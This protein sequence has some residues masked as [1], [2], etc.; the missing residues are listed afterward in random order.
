MTQV[1]KED[2]AAKYHAKVEAYRLTAIILYEENPDEF[3]NIV[4]Q[5]KD[6]SIVI[7]HH[8]VLKPMYEQMFKEPCNA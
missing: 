7:T 2:E 6:G 5:K 4:T 1:S 3:K 8:P